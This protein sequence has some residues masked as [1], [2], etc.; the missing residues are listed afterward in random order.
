MGDIDI[1]SFIRCWSMLK[2]WRLRAPSIIPRV[3][4]FWSG[5]ARE[6]ATCARLLRGEKRPL[7]KQ[8]FKQILFPASCLHCYHTNHT[9]VIIMNTIILGEKH[10]YTIVAY[11]IIKVQFCEG[12]ACIQQFGIMQAIQWISFLL[13]IIII[14]LYIRDSHQYA[15]ATRNSWPY[16]LAHSIPFVFLTSRNASYL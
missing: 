13:C 16:T 3:F 9:L 7:D 14:S 8:L 2:C 1:H 12:P 6:R 4:A 5:W 10:Y 11:S 15:I